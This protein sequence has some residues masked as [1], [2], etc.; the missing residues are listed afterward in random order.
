MTA[1]ILSADI[2][3]SVSGR[4]M[5]TS[6][7]RSRLAASISR[8]SPP[9]GAIVGGLGGLAAV[10]GA[11]I[12]WESISFVG[13]SESMTGWEG[14]NGGKIIAVLGVVAIAIAIAWVLA[15]E[16]PT[17]GGLMVTAGVLILLVGILNF[18]SVTDDVDSANAIIAGA[19]SVGI[20]LFIDLLAGVAI[21]VGGA[22]GVIARKS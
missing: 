11:F 5:A 14:G 15:I 18:L 10:L 6:E 3:P 1:T 8:K 21:I 20:G 2:L 12:T 22:L 4:S 13:T 19:A 16:L 9:L 7:R 17:P